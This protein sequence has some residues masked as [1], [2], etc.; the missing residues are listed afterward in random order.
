VMA[1]PR[2]FAPLAH[3]R[4]AKYGA[5]MYGEG[6]L[7][8]WIVWLTGRAVVLSLECVNVHR[9]SVTDPAH[10]D[11]PP[12]PDSLLRSVFPGRRKL[13]RQLWVRLLGVVPVFLFA[14]SLTILEWG[15]PHDKSS[16]TWAQTGLLLSELPFTDAV[17]MMGRIGF[18]HLLVWGELI[19]V[20][21]WAISIPL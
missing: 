14:I 19:I 5:L 17:A 18:D 20:V 16:L 2:L 11:S 6:S 4:R 1:A 13:A 3:S 7:F 21:A 10:P 12:P 9:A 15:L 8:P